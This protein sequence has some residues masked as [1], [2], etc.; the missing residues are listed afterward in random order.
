MELDG[1][2]RAFIYPEWE[3]V[4]KSQDLNKQESSG[5]EHVPSTVSKL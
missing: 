5:F 4:K 3:R 1:N 2:R